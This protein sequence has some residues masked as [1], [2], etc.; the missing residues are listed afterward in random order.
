MKG[1][2][3]ALQNVREK[4]FPDPDPAPRTACSTC[5][6]ATCTWTCPPPPRPL[7]DT[8]DETGPEDFTGESREYV[9]KIARLC[10]QHGAQLMLVNTP[11]PAQAL[12]AMPRYFEADAAIAESA[13]Q[14]RGALLQLQSGPAGAV[15]PR[16]EMFRDLSHERG[17]RPGVQ[18]LC[19][20]RLAAGE[21]VSGLF[22]TPEQAKERL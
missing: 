9:Q 16:P 3:S 14:A 2:R 19:V 22:Y 13:R 11:C 5:G 12:R 6:T 21:D 18:R 17:R 10:R 15:S 1:P 20:L 7:P 4:L 8:V